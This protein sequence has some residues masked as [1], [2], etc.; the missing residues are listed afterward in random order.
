MRQPAQQLQP[1]TTNAFLNA[2]FAFALNLSAFD[3]KKS[4]EYRRRTFIRTLS[5]DTTR[6]DTIYKYI[7]KQNSFMFYKT[8][9]GQSFFLTATIRNKQTC[10]RNG[11]HVGSARARVQRAFIDFDC[12]ADTC[13]FE[14]DQRQAVFIFKN[15]TLQEVQL[16][17]YYK[18][19]N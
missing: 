4:E 13:K 1:E 17:N 11:L 3:T 10:F 2:P 8:R 19:N 6:K 12:V 5:S 16:N 14:N 9:Q 18:N 15:N 7:H